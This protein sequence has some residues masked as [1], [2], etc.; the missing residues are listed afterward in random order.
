MTSK[1]RIGILGIGG[2]GGYFGGKLA[3][4]YKNSE[5]IEIIFIARGDNAKAIRDNGIKIIMPASELIAQP[6][7]VS[8]DPSE[9]G[10]LDFVVCTLKTYDLA[11]GIKQYREC[12][13]P[14]TVFLPL[15]NGVSASEEIRNLLP[16]NEIW[17]GFAYIVVRLISPGVVKETGILHAIH[18]GTE[19][20]FSDKLLMIQK[21]LTDA[22][23][24][25]HLSENILKEKW[26][27]FLFISSM[28]TATSYFNRTIGEILAD[29]EAQQAWMN[30][31]HEGEAV[32]IAK[33][34][35][36][37]GDIIEKCKQR[38]MALPGETT[39]SMH[40]DI[41]NN[42]RAEIESLTNYVVTEGN[43]LGVPTPT[44][45]MMLKALIKK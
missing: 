3:A 35:P 12:F 39:S 20:D 31:L 2:V 13:H 9:I 22:G 1:Y 23:I 8:S 24:D 21:I 28:A 40:N 16:A 19:N 4:K 26:E 15:L 17:D 14:G 45:E 43:I 33:R 44:Y 10:M 6:S 5:S 29:I 30:L 18:F 37:P 32:A 27:K 11:S 7:L 25:N 34:I 38:A 41:K 42:K 36:L